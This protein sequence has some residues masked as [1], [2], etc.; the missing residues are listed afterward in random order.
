MGSFG[1]IDDRANR[2]APA[3][4]SPN[5]NT[6]PVTPVAVI[7]MACRLPGGI[8]SPEQLWEALLRGDDLVTEI[9]PTV[10]T[11][12][13]TTTPSQGC[14]VGRCRSGEHSSTTLPVLMPSSS[15]SAS[16]RRSRL[17]RSTGCC[18]KA[19]GKPWSTP[20]SPR[21]RC[22]N[23]SPAC[24]W[25]WLHPFRLSIGD[26]R[27][28]AAME[29]PYGFQG[30]IFSMASGRIAYTLGLQGPALTVDTACSSGLVA[31][32]WPVAA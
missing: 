21:R 28:P 8:D 3:M 27:F 16:A 17:I 19:H 23:R 29:G 24:S 13:N 12:T 31:V 9:P 7:G 26:G 22:A 30:N 6:A 18:W 32:I 10:G 1:A 2:S 15:G 5:V 14:P 25:D 20:V 11:P 4:S